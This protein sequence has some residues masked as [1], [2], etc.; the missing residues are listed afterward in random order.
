MTLDEEIQKLINKYRT[1]AIITIEEIEAMPEYQ[2]ELKELM[3]KYK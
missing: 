1:R 2:K 3:E